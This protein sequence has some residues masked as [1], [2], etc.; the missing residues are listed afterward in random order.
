MTVLAGV[1]CIPVMRSKPKAT[2]ISESGEV[3]NSAT[4]QFTLILISCF[5][6]VVHGRWLKTRPLTAFYQ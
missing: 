5:V 6:P 1:T 2:T 4:I 3:S